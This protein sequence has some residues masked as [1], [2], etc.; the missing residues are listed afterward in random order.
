MHDVATCF[1]EPSTGD[2]NAGY[3]QYNGIN[4][5]G[6]TTNIINGGLECGQGVESYGSQ[7]RADYYAAW[8][9]Y[10]GMAGENEAG[11]GCGGMQNQFPSNSGGKTHGYWDQDWSGDP[12]CK[13]VNW[14]TGYSIY[15]RDDYKRC[16]CDKFGSGEA[17]C[18][19]TGN[20]SPS[21]SPPTPGPN[22]VDPVDPVDPDQDFAPDDLS[23]GTQ[24][25]NVFDGKCGDNCD[26]CYWSWP[27]SDADNCNSKDAACRCK[28]EKTE[29]YTFVNLCQG[30]CLDTCDFCMFSWPSDDPDTFNSADAACR[31]AD[32][33]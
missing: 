18:P 10:F 23:F 5:F 15:A 13:A 33:G 31:C 24:C 9:N 7:A 14:M 27:T 30:K 16:I 19:S 21:P 8:I 11:F 25:T 1:F 6:I 2:T 3:N 29:D 26:A 17:D 22:P 4:A 12:K 28:P 20:P 32:D